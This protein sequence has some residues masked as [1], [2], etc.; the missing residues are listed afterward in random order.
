L[1]RFFKNNNNAFIFWYF[2]YDYQN[3]IRLVSHKQY[4]L[5]LGLNYKAMPKFTFLSRN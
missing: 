5:F 1:K 4:A 3:L 2:A